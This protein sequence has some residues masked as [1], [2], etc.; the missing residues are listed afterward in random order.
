M[1][2]LYEWAHKKDTPTIMNMLV[3]HFTVDDVNQGIKNLAKGKV[4]D[5]DKF[6]AKFL[7]WRV[8]LLSLT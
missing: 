8:E 1:R 3:E 5:I 4:E 7:K 2:H 6:Q